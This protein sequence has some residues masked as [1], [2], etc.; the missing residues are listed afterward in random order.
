M[1][2]VS[3]TCSI[4]RTKIFINVLKGE[5]VLN[6]ESLFKGESGVNQSSRVNQG[7]SKL[8]GGLV[9]NVSPCSKVS[10]G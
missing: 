4:W 9:L 5:S 2:Q 1:D 6:S 8:T 3:L 10:Q 7:E